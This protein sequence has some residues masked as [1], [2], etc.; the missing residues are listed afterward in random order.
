M[1]QNISKPITA[2]STVS[3]YLNKSQKWIDSNFV[4]EKTLKKKLNTLKKMG[5]MRA[6][7]KEIK[8]KEQRSK[9]KRLM[10]LKKATRKIKVISNKSMQ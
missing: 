2:V 1:L 7:Y 5:S 9:N 8:C 6:R 3:N 10:P 4:K